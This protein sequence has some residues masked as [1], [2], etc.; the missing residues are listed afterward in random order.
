MK[1][2]ILA[3]THAARQGF[4]SVPLFPFIRSHLRKRSRKQGP[5][6]QA[7]IVLAFPVIWKIAGLFI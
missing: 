2:Q 7:A 1:K 6:T 3:F 5:D 4:V